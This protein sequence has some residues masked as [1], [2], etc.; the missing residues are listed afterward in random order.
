MRN[1][2]KVEVDIINEI[3]EYGWIVF[4][5]WLSEDWRNPIFNANKNDG[6]EIVKDINLKG[7]LTSLK[8]EEKLRQIGL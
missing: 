1:L 7:F 3:K 8:R 5:D 2:K 6:T 4:L